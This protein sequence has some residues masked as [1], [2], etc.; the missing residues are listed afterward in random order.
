[1]NIKSAAHTNLF[2]NKYVLYIFLSILLLFELLMLGKYPPGLSEGW[3]SD[4]AYHLNWQFNG[5]MAKDIPYGA[6]W[7]TGIGKT[8]FLLH[9]VF[10]KLFG[11]GLYQA[12]LVTL[13]CGLILL[14][15]VFI[16]TYKN[17]S[18]ES[19]LL[20]TFFLGSSIIFSISIHDAR[21]DT[22][23]CLFA[24]LSF[25]LLSSA[26][27]RNSN[28]LFFMAGFFSALSVD[29]SFRGIE[30]VMAVYLF[31]VLFFKKESFL[32][33][34]ALLLTGS[35]VA[36]IIWY[37]LNVLPMGIYKFVEYH[38][39]AGMGEGGAYTITS[40]FSEILRFGVFLFNSGKYSYFAF[41]EALY[42]VALIVISLKSRSEYRLV[43]RIIISWFLVV[44]F[45]MSVMERTTHINNLLVYYPHI[46][47][48][49]G[50][51]IKELYRLR[52]KYAYVLIIFIA[53]FACVFRSALFVK[54]GYPSYIKKTYDMNG[55]YRQL[56]SKVN[57]NES[58]IGTTNHWYGFTDAQYYGGQFYLSRVMAILRE[59][60]PA[61]DYPDDYERAKGLLDVFK[62][63]EIKYVIADEYFKPTITPYFSDSQ[64]PAKNFFLIDTVLDHCLGCTYDS[65]SPCKTEIYKIIS[66][67]P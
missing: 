54:Y 12:R 43:Y 40:L 50:V 45:I 7:S 1:M 23:H 38:L 65:I 47:I 4:I 31:H 33:R 34:S 49:G 3:F 62:K 25:Y 15:L 10:Y 56:R 29:I 59:L 17:I 30:N 61:E 28:I 6:S 35:F 57:L 41:F 67:D 48:L 16:W 55:Y 22:M 9:H 21:Q 53:L 32:K 8:F 24:F 42:L 13:L 36:F 51:G 44:F 18:K 58:I 64:L 20:A 27:L 66:Y 46:C 5:W 63:R 2:L 60:K 37:S 26:V 14:I 19:A 52:K 11:V 39:S